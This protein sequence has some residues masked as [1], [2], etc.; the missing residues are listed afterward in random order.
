MINEEITD[1]EIRV[2]DSDGSQ[3]GIMLSKDALQIAMDRDL[4]LVKIAPQAV[5]PV[6]K[7]MDYGKYRFELSKKEKEAKK[8]QKI[9][10]IK[11]IRLSLMIDV[12]DF[13]TK[14]NHAIRFIKDGDKVKV[15]VRFRGRELQHTSAG[16]TLLDRFAE[17]CSEV[18]AVE[19]KPKLEGRSMVMFIAAK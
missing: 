6:C 3:L 11:E 12:H 9:T 16:I 10:E 8:N 2:I 19:K 13:N 7:I 4:D 14:V 17:A 1:K 18:A 15:A 5:P